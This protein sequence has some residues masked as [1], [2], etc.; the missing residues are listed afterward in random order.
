MGGFFHGWRRKIGLLTLMMACL[1]AAGWVRSLSTI[2]M[3]AF[4]SRLMN[5]TFVSGEGSFGVTGN[6]VFNLRQL[7]R[8]EYGRKFLRVKIEQTEK[9]TSRDEFRSWK[10]EGAEFRLFRSTSESDG[11]V[12]MVPYWSIVVPLTLISLLF[13][14]S[15]PCKSIRNKPD[16][17]A[18]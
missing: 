4:P 10:F 15:K 14:L 12:P 3:L 18:S 13:L 17:R 8:E 1:F 7:C 11:V 9:Q 6:F 2:D 5:Y 16:E